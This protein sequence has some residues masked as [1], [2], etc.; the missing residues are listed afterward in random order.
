LDLN[1]TEEGMFIE[2]PDEVDYTPTAKRIAL[3]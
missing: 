2:Y 1:E 3:E